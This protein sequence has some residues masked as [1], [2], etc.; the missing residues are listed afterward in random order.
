MPMNVFRVAGIVSFA[1]L[2]AHGCGWQEQQLQVEQ[3]LQSPPPI[4][5]ARANADLRVL[6]AEKA[7]VGQRIAEGAAA[8]TPTG[9]VMGLLT[10]TERVETQV[11]S[12]E[13]NRRIAARISEIE[14][15]CGIGE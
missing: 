3:Q 5:C 13:Y 8:V 6:Q 12:G 1:L 15:A 9:A 7:T 2:V 14:R 10:G 11:A 4:D